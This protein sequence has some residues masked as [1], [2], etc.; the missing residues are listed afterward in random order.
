[1]RPTAAAMLV[2]A[3]LLGGATAPLLR[4]AHGEEAGVRQYVVGVGNMH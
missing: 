2:L 3:L 4:V 1:M